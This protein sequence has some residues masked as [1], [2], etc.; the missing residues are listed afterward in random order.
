M[1]PS[2]PTLATPES[3]PLH[4]TTL[5]GIHGLTLPQIAGILHY[6]A[7]TL[8]ASAVHPR[9]CTTCENA[10][11]VA[12]KLGVDRGALYRDELPAIGARF[13]VGDDLRDLD[14]LPAGSMVLVDDGRAAQV[15]D[16]RRWSLVAMTTD[17]DTTDFVGR[18]GPVTVAWAP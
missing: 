3:E 16:R 6:V 17:Y 7:G 2:R 15:D 1:L 13:A 14:V 9:G 8:G 12:A 18:F 4:T 5:N 11:Q 10:V